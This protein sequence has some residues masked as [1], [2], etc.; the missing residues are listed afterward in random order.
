MNTR[1]SRKLHDLEKEFVVSN[2]IGG[3]VVV[4]S[5][6]LAKIHPLVDA[7]T[8]INLVVAG[9]KGVHHVVFEGVVVRVVQKRNRVRGWA[10]AGNRMVVELGK[11]IRNA[12]IV[13][14]NNVP[15]WGQITALQG[16]R[17]AKE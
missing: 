17:I 13:V 5:D 10:V 14:G 16:A 9:I 3:W 2:S 7:V 11:L 1:R 4:R 12:G 8:G 15:T 6:A